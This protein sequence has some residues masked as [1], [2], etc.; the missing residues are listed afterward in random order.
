MSKQKLL[1]IYLPNNQKVFC[2]Q[3]EEARILYQQV[4]EYFKYVD[5]N[6]GDTIFDVG[7]NIGLFSLMVNDLYAGKVKVFA[8]EP[9]PDIFSALNQNA[10]KYNPEKII[11]Y[12]IGLGSKSQT[13]DFAYYPKATAI[14]SMYPDSSEE[15]KKLFSKTIRKSLEQFSFPL[16]LIKFLPSP[17]LY[18]AIDKIVDFVHHE[19]KVTCQ[20]KTVSQI[21]MER[22]INQV[23]LLKID[24]ERAELDVLMGIED[25]D[26]WKIKQIVI[27]VH[28]INGRV[29]FIINLLK[30]KGFQQIS[31]E[32]DTAFKHLDIYILYAS[33]TNKKF[34]SE[35]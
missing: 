5:I 21:L 22:S 14:S 26:W 15:G 24:V 17:L 18:F 20:V 19:K 33:R 3:A 25:E 2:I 9:I 11:V 16:N 12:Q 1:K 7:A 23:D 28:N 32:Q 31:C 30:D 8:F 27:E 29:K 13:T 34:V 6:Q 10:R 4:Q 35:S